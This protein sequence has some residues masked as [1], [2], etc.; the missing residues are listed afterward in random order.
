MLWI[1]SVRLRYFREANKAR[2]AKLL[3]TIYIPDFEFLIR[4]HGYGG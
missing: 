4:E 2:D 1:F 3:K